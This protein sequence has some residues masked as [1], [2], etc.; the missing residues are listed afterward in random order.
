MEKTYVFT[1]AEK[2]ENRQEIITMLGR[3]A[4]LKMAK[5]ALEIKRIERDSRK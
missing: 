5:R 4:I 1:K 2:R 3:D